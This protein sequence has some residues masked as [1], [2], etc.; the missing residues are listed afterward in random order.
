MP[1]NPI[2]GLFIVVFFIVVL[3]LIWFAFKSYQD[4]KENQEL[5]R[6]N[7][8]LIQENKN[9]RADFRALEKYAN[10]QTDEIMSYERKERLYKEYQEK[11]R[12]RQLTANR[13][14]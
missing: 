4:E 12:Q 10:K 13:E 14:S 3:L 5:I 6:I 2:N 8:K 1:S 9:I 7:Q 11:C